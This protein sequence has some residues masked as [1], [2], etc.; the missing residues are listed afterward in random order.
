[1]SDPADV[2]LE[3]LVIVGRL[4][5]PFGVLGETRLVPEAEDADWL[6]RLK[7]DRFYLLKQNMPPESIGLEVRRW[8]G[9]VLIVKFDGVDSPEEVGKLAGAS[10]AIQEKDRPNLA[11]DEFYIDQLPGLKVIDPQGKEMGVVRRTVE[12][13]GEVY[14]EIASHNGEM[15]LLPPEKGLIEKIDLKAGEVRLRLPLV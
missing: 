15:F 2:S 13:R 10:V 3:E 7:K 6:L 14:L 4:S 1:M 5:R 11:E 12:S 9:G 8:Q